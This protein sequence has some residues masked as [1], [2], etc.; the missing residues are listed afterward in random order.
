[1]TDFPADKGILSFGKQ[2]GYSF[3]M[4]EIVQFIL[5]AHIRRGLNKIIFNSVK[6]LHSQVEL[7]VLIELERIR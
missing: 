3:W 5:K 4:A 7:K 2:V 6:C 1:M